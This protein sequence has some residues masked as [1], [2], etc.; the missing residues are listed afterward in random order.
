MAFGQIKMSSHWVLSPGGGGEV[1][2]RGPSGLTRG[3][4][5]FTKLS[6]ATIVF[7]GCLSD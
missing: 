7:M 2:V 6:V 3:S 1:R 4:P 5:L